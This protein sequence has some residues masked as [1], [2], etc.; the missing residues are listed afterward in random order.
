MSDEHAVNETVYFTVTVRTEDRGD[1]WFARTIETGIIDYGA[2]QDEA[3]AN[4][5]DGNERV[6]RWYKTQ[7]RAALDRFMQ[8]RGLAY[9][10]GEPDHSGAAA[11]V[12]V[13]RQ[14]AA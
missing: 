1:H 9:T 13:E 11:S 6:V 10:V 5:G 7:G 12:T 2:T 14:L 8:E 4:V 3:E